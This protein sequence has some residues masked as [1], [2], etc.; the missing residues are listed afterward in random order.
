RRA[1][2]LPL[3]AMQ[4]AI[5]DFGDPVLRARWFSPLRWP[6]STRS[7]PTNPIVHSPK[8]GMARSVMR[9]APP[10]LKQRGFLPGIPLKCQQAAVK[11]LD[12]CA[13][14]VGCRALTLTVSGTKMREINSN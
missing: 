14:A 6:S 9:C 5:D 7:E 12:T 13:H 2:A 1:R 8:V 11:V 3:K 4:A 10:F